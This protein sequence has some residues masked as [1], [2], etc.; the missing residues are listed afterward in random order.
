MR[1]RIMMTRGRRR[2]KRKERER[3]RE[4]AVEKNDPG[5]LFYV[6]REWAGGWDGWVVSFCFFS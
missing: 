6:R 4:I 5:Y 3:E 1:M 2:M